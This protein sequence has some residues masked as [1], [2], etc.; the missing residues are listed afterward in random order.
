MSRRPGTIEHPGAWTGLFLAFFLIAWTVTDALVTTGGSRGVRVARPGRVGT[1]AGPVR[2]R[3]GRFFVRT[4]G[5]QFL[6]E[7]PK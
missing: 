1:P 5:P 7:V 4:P 3:N 6:G 2:E